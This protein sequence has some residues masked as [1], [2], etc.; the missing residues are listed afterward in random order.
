MQLAAPDGTPHSF[1]LYQVRFEPDPDS[2]AGQL[3]SDGKSYA[4][5]G[6]RGGFISILHLQISGKKAMSITDFL[7]GCNISDWKLMS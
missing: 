7:R 4:K 6:V 1:K 3:L 5:I 2:R